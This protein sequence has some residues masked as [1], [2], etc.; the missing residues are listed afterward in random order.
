MVYTARSN[1]E[2]FSLIEIMVVMFIAG[3]MMGV[4]VISYNTYTKM[5]STSATKTNLKT[6][7]NAINIYKMQTGVYPSRLQDLKERPK[8]EAAGK[9]WPGEL[10]EGSIANDGWG[11]P[12]YY[13][14]P[15]SGK[16]PYDLYSYGANGPEEGAPE[17]RI[18]AQDV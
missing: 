5:A 18:D 6:I 7:K 17:E 14:M 16:R 8:D 9:K 1:Q 15:G 4:A 10:I 11:N 12:F 2:G 13:K 3:I